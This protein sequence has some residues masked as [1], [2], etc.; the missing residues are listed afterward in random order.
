MMEGNEDDEEGEDE[1]GSGDGVQEQVDTRGTVSQERGTGRGCGR[2]PNR[3]EVRGAIGGRP[4]VRRTNN[5]KPK[6]NKIDR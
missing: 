4:N 2:R 1:G 3:E 5:L 6:R